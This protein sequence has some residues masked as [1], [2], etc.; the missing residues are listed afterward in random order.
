MC[1]RSESSDLCR[2]QPSPDTLYRFVPKQEASLVG[3]DIPIDLYTF[4][5]EYGDDM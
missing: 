2:N 3:Y 1:A 5:V 4:L